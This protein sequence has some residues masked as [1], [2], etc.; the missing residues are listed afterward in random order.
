[1]REE[2]G[3]RREERRQERGEE[4][5]YVKERPLVSCFVRRC[6]NTNRGL[7]LCQHSPRDPSSSPP[8]AVL[9]SSSAR[10]RGEF[11]RSMADIFLRSSISSRVES[12]GILRGRR[13][14]REGEGEKENI[15]SYS[16]MPAGPEGG[17]F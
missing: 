15:S 12:F 17:Q 16:E 14:R 9:S 6:E 2:T 3:E 4:S 5:V 11:M 1:M 8:R 10:V 13:R 7:H